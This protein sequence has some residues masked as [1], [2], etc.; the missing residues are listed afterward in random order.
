M[1]PD[2]MPENDQTPAAENEPERAAKTPF[3]WVYPLRWVWP[4]LS[5]LLPACLGCFY[6]ARGMQYGQALHLSPLR[7]LFNTL[8]SAREYFGGVRKS[9]ADAF[10]GVLTVGSVFIIVLWAALIVYAVFLLLEHLSERY[11]KTPEERAR[12]AFRLALFLPRRWVLVLFGALRVV[13]FLFVW[14]FARVTVSGLNAGAD[15]FYLTF[16]PCPVAAAVMGLLEIGLDVAESK[17]R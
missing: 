14:W 10:W 15:A 4:L 5:L 9:S 16:D 17:T 11:A 1:T 13:P 8:V 6:V 12:A 2:R 3:R 7:L